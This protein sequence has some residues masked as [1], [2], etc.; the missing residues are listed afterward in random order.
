MK[1]SQT[2]ELILTT[3]KN[4]F[5]KQGNLHAT[6]QDIANEAGINR[7]L[8]HYYFRSREL[9]FEKVLVDA[10]GIMTKRMHSVLT[11]DDTFKNKIEQFLDFFIDE[12]LEFPY[13]QNFIISELNRPGNT[14]VVEIGKN[15][16][17]SIFFT[18][19]NEI[20]TEMKKGTIPVSTPMEFIINLMSLCSYP[21]SARPMIQ[22]I[23]D[24]DDAQY[25]AMIKDR[26]KQIHK[27][28][29]G[30]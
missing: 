15:M 2:E 9:L 12:A 5:F 7:A 28:I 26:K 29:F 6:T 14:Q 10:H 24:L 27:L 23:L 20:A 17:E 18:F 8:I 30:D 16:R 3:A 13:L 25:L 11:S 1:E 21:I 22:M 19:S 4:V